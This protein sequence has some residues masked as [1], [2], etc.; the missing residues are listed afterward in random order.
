MRALAGLTLLLS[1]ACAAL[2]AWLLLSAVPRV[3]GAAASASSEL[4][5]GQAS[6][7]ALIAHGLS[8]E[9]FAREYGHVQDLLTRCAEI[10]YFTRAI[11]TNRD[12]LIVASVGP[13]ADLKI[14][15]KLADVTPGARRIPLMLGSERLGDLV[16]WMPALSSRAL[17]LDA[18]VDLLRIASRALAMV[19]LA[20]A[21][22]LVLSLLLPA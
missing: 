9:L 5:R 22:A 8:V 21:V 2:S 12:K 19:S 4:A 3:A 18:D 6:A 11:V 17:T 14:G 13:I 10:G 16:M 15:D 7:D 20:A 1:V